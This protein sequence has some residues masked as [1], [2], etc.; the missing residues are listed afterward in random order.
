[1][2]ARLRSGDRLLFIARVL[3]FWRTFNP[4]SGT[5]RVPEPAII[6][7]GEGGECPRSPEVLQKNP[8]NPCYHGA[9]KEPNLLKSI[10]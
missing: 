4:I 7:L 6:S 5:A 8:M 1:M 3:L 10:Q 2:I 9:P